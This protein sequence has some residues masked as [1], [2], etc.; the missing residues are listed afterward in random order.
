MHTIS[1]GPRRHQKSSSR[2][3]TN[4]DAS[5]FQNLASRSQL[6]TEYATQ[7]LLHASQQSLKIWSTKSAKKRHLC[8]SIS[9]HSL[10]CHFNFY[11]PKPET[12]VSY[13]SS[14][15][16]VVQLSKCAN[17]AV[18]KHFQ[19]IIWHSSGICWLSLASLNLPPGSNMNYQKKSVIFPGYL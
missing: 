5:L 10:H 19:V 13:S 3:G 6:S 16:I 7:L 8:A 15:Q 14:R 1:Q 18:I 17:H 4:F 2:F 12:S 9:A 11:K